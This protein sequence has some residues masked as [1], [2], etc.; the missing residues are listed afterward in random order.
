MYPTECRP[1]QHLAAIARAY[2]NAWRQVDELR[3]LRGRDGFPD[4]PD[5]CFLPVAGAYV[6]VAGGGDRRV[7]LERI[8][9]V[10]SVSALA[11]WRVSQGIY[12]FDP[13]LYQAI[14]STELNGELPADL[15]TRLPEWCVYIELQGSPGLHG[16]FVHLERDVDT[17]QMELRLLL[18]FDTGL[19]PMPLHLGQWDL[20]TALEEMV[21]E[22]RKHARSHALPAP[23]RAAGVPGALSVRRERRSRGAAAGTAHAEAHETRRAIVPA[24]AADDLGRGPAHRGR[25]ASRQGD[26]L[27][28]GGA[29]RHPCPAAGAYPPCP[30]AYVLDGAASRRARCAA[31]VAGADPGEHR[32]ARPAAGDGETH[33][34]S[35]IYRHA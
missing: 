20:V 22:T 21:R 32:R 8:A 11:A 33:G 30:L 27:A 15:L 4:W 10:A 12:R 1:R 29:H 14:V 5:W 26:R 13:D 24:R 2:P 3:A 23:G 6:I 9:D 34:R 17:L 16:F 19:L 25:A 18:D 7:P 31:Q 35:L 28:A